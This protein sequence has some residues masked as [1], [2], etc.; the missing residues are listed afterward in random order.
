MQGAADTAGKRVDRRNQVGNVAHI[1]RAAEMAAVDHAFG[2]HHGQGVGAED[3][4]QFRHAVQRQVAGNRA[5]MGLGADRIAAGLE[6]AGD[7]AV[8]AFDRLHRAGPHIRLQ[9][10]VGRHGVDQIAAFGDDR[11]HP[12]DVLVAEGLAQRV[13]SHQADHR[14]AQGIDPFVGGAG[15]MGLLADILYGHAD[16]SVAGLAQAD[17]SGR[18]VLVGVDHHRDVD[19]IEL[20]PR[21]QFLLAAEI[22]DLPL[23]A[24][25]LAERDFHIFFR[26]RGHKGDV[27]GQRIGNAGQFQPERRAQHR[28]ELQI[29]AA[30]VRRAGFGIGR[31][32]VRA[33]HRV[34]LA[35]YGDIGAGSAR[36]QLG[37]NTGQGQALLTG[38]IQVAEELADGGGGFGFL[39]TEFRRLADFL[40]H[41]HDLLGMFID[42]LADQVF[43]LLSV[44]SVCASLPYPWQYFLRL[45]SFALKKRKPFLYW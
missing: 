2:R 39:E 14:S 18:R 10:H 12:D 32:A 27:A 15:G 38:I 28:A 40:R 34:Q 11:M 19:V 1:G 43:E 9:P 29:V 8:G 33:D 13:D 17:P 7:L 6:G 4:V 41:L 22:A 3:F 16:K 35:D 20:A 25:L 44:H 26:R 45:I 36:L 30:G 37:L 24:Q 42:C 23:F 5:D 31:R 21:H